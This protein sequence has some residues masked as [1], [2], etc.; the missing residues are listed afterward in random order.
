MP[1]KA[2]DP[3]TP[4]TNIREASGYVR[5]FSFYGVHDLEP[6][7]QQMRGSCPFPDCEKPTNHFYVNPSTGQWDCKF[8]SRK[9][10]VYTFMEYIHDVWYGLTPEAHYEELAVERPGIPAFV[11]ADYKLAWNN[12][13]SEWM[14]PAFSVEGKINNLY[15]WRDYHNDKENRWEKPVMS[16]AAIKQTLFGLDKLRPEKTR[17]LLVAEGHWD[18]M[19]MYGLLW[20]TINPRTGAAL[21]EEYDVIG[22]PGAGTFPKEYLPHLDARDVRFLQDADD[23]GRRGIEAICKAIATHSVLPQKVYAINWP[24]GTEPGYDIR[25]LCY[26]YE[27]DGNKAFKFILSN[28]KVRKIEVGKTD[29]EGYDPDIEPIPCET[30]D[31]LVDNIGQKLHLTTGLIDTLAVMLAVNISIKLGGPAL[32]SHIIGPPSSGKTTLAE[33]LAAAH[34]HCYS[35]SKITGVFSGL[36]GRSDASMLPLFQDRTVIIKDFTTILSSSQADQERIFGE[37]R[38]V[39]DGHADVAYRNRIKRHYSDIRFTMLTCVTDAI[40]RYNTSEMGERFLQC[41]IDSHWNERGILSRCV[42]GGREHVRRA[43]ANVL[44]DITNVSSTTNRNPEQKAKTWGYILHLHRLAAEHPTH[45]QGVADKVQS[46]EAFLDW[47]ADLGQW[48]A[49]ARASVDRD[50]DKQLHY[51]PRVELGLRLAQQLTKLATA[52]CLVLNTDHVTSRVR[53]VIRKVALDTGSSFQQE[54]LL[55]LAHATDSGLTREIISQRIGLSSTSIQNRLQDLRELGAA[56]YM[57]TRPVT[58]TTGK[59]ANKGRDTYVY[60]LSEPLLKLAKSIGF[61]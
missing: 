4:R 24:E 13:L 17:P 9:G 11:F 54:I 56:T 33:L 15:C 1:L 25:D 26:A 29:N 39:Y 20:S 57:K 43:L 28:L 47:V 61:A 22:M 23:A 31:E 32:W 58:T 21:A 5:F 8:C 59:M 60:R 34:D 50:R 12:H 2:R 18:A 44:N 41:E 55:T 14:L 19:A 10:N 51:R 52:L 53:D 37:L 48:V 49:Y 30:Y 7:N 6:E 40:R 36:M 38:D 35:T 27:G 3:S 46:D 16:G 42:T 45:V